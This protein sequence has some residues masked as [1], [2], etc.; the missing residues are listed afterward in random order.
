MTRIG[1]ILVI[2]LFT[3]AMS[4]AVHAATFTVNTI[5]TRLM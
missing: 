2:C 5:A 3:F 1:R 4:A